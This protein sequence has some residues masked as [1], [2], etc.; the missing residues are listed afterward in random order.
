MQTAAER[1]L[2]YGSAG[3]LSVLMLL[4]AG[5]V[6]MRYVFNNPIAG[7]YEITGILL[8]AVICI[9]FAY[10]QGMRGHI[11]LDFLPNR[12][13]PRPRLVLDIFA[14]AVGLLLFA[15]MTYRGWLSAWDSWTLREFSA[16]LVEFP[17]Y[18]ARFLLA[19][20]AGVMCLRLILDITRQFARLMG[21]A[22]TE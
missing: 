12:L 19:I 17:V 4:T 21:S 18:P 3:L 20:A 13:R 5:D 1:W 2:S 22:S 11:A 8:L 10:V 9:S 6:V 15:A 7:A 14:L 16:G